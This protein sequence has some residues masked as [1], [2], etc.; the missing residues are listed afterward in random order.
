MYKHARVYKYLD[1]VPDDCLLQPLESTQG[2]YGK[3]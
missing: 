1:I 2:M 3:Y